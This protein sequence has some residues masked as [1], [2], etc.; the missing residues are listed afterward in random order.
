[1]KNI[2]FAVIAGGV[3]GAGLELWWSNDGEWSWFWPGTGALLAG[4]SALPVP[5]AVKGTL[6]GAVLGYF[7]SALV[8]VLLQPHRAWGGAPPFLIELML[9][10]ATVW[11]FV[12]L[13]AIFCGM[14]GHQ[15]AAESEDAEGE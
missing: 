6:I 11:V 2:I 5:P 10:K 14:V 9:A 8:V 7:A 4:L 13:G 15:M 3:I 12:A 1:M